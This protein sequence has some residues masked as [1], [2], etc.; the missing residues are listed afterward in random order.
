[1]DGPDH[2]LCRTELRVAVLE[3]HNA[4][5]AMAL[6]LAE[7]LQAADK[8]LIFALIFGIAGWI[9]AIVRHLQLLQHT[10]R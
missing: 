10:K 9:F 6:V 1:M 8:K 5:V 3:E 2:A 7:R 4:C